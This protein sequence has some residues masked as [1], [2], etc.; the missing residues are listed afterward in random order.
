[1]KNVIEPCDV[2]MYFLS[3]T[4][5]LQVSYL[6]WIYMYSFSCIS[7]SI[8]IEINCKR[9]MQMRKLQFQQLTEPTQKYLQ[10]FPVLRKI[11]KF[12]AFSILNYVN[13]FVLDPS[14]ILSF[15]QSYFLLYRANNEYSSK[16]IYIYIFFTWYY[17]GNYKVTVSFISSL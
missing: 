11:S 3:G 7:G 4:E 14:F 17:L 9:L 6:G 2:H 16:G 5:L 10:L 8:F 15:F 12:F 13:K 1:M